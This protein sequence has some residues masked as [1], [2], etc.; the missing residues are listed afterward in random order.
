[1]ASWGV[2]MKTREVFGGRS[3]S[4]SEATRA[5]MN[6]AAVLAERR[7]RERTPSTRTPSSARTRPSTLPTL[8]APIIVTARCRLI[9]PPSRPGYRGEISHD[10]PGVAGDIPR[11]AVVNH[12]H[13]ARACTVER[14]HDRDRRPAATR[15]RR[16]RLQIGHELL[17][18]KSVDVLDHH[19]VHRGSDARRVIVRAIR[20]RHQE[21]F[22]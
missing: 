13:P 22:P 6:R 5:P 16:P 4:R 18:V 8:P 21:G 14:S 20:A 10:T 7:V 2:A 19:L 17:V 3:A 12:V 1:M 9:N 15:L 11:G